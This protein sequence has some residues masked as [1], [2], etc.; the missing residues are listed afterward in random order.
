M[1]QRHWKLFH[2][3]SLKKCFRE[4]HSHAS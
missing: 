1:W 4:L 2:N 3:R